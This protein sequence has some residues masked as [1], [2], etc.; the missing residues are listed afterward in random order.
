M[1]HSY[2][3]TTTG[4]T[5]SEVITSQKMLYLA[6]WAETKNLKCFNIRDNILCFY[7]MYPYGALSVSSS[8][9]RDPI[10]KQM[11]TLRT[12]KSYLDKQLHRQ[13]QIDFFRQ[14]ILLYKTC[15]VFRL[16]REVAIKHKHKIQRK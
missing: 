9:S 15:F 11:N 8:L 10:L 7:F 14:Y 16:L 3:D 6:S 1:F 5:I 12:L 4:T 2:S 13:L